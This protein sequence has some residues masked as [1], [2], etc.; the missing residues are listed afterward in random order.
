M[1]AKNTVRARLSPAAVE[2]HFATL[3]APW[4]I[5]EGALCAEWR[6]D[7]FAPVAELIRAVVQI[8]QK[9]NHH[10]HAEFGFNYFRVRYITHSAGALSALDFICAAETSA[11]VRRC[12][13]A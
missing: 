3:G 7:D 2:E 1:D 13:R 12:L 10:P 11:A 5:T 6:F 9:K 8:A 4:Q